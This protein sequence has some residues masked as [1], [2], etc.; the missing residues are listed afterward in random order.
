[1]TGFSELLVIT[2]ISWINISAQNG[3]TPQDFIITVGEFDTM[4]VATYS[5]TI[6][7]NATTAASIP[8]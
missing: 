3:E 4:N 5:G 7:V 2:D 1:M 6:A 8:V